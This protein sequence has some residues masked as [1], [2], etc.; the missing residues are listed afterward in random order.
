MFTLL[1]ACTH[2]HTDSLNVYTA[3]CMHTPPHRFPK[4]L[5]CLMHA[6]TSTHIPYLLLTLLDACTHLH[7]HSIPVGYTAWCMHTP[8]HTFP[9]CCLHCFLSCE[10]PHRLSLEPDRCS[11][12]GW[13]YW[14]NS[15]CWPYHCARGQSP[16]PTGWLSGTWSHLQ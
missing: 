6:H 5:H 11:G 8:P 2:L 16:T 9:T 12:Q 10:S 13:T 3:W 14:R 1:D 15:A 7:T 4:C